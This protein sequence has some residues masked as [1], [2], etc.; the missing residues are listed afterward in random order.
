MRAATVAS[1]CWR[2]SA[3]HRQAV[4]SFA[5]GHIKRAVGPTQQALGRFAGQQGRTAEADGQLDQVAISRKILGLRRESQAL[6]DHGGGFPAGVGQ[7]NQK[8]LATKAEHHVHVAQLAFD[9]GGDSL[10][11]VIASAVAMGVVDLFEMVDVQHQQRQGLQVPTRHVDF[12]LQR[13]VHGNAVAGVRERVAQGALSGGAVEQG[14]AH[15]V[16]QCGQQRLKVAQFLLAETLIATE[17][18][19]TQL[20]AFVAEGVTDRVVA[21]LAVFQA[22]VAGLVLVAQGVERYET[23]NFTVEEPK[24]ALWLKTGLQLQTQL[25]AQLRKADRPL[26]KRGL[27]TKA[28]AL[29]FGAIEVNCVGLG[30]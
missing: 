30:R 28:Q 9:R 20:L 19:F 23:L 26:Q 13:L 10:K 29:Q 11:H 2:E 24:N 15:R 4:A 21:A 14:V 22:Q 25:L 5:L 18:Q 6:A 7:Q 3:R 1:P 17:H 27:L 8:L 12:P 16:Q